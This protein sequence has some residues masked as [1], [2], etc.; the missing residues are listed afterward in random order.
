MKKWVDQ[1]LDKEK[2]GVFNYKHPKSFHNLGNL[3]KLARFY[4][5]RDYLHVFV[6]IDSN[7]DGFLEPNEVL[8]A[9]KHVLPKNDITDMF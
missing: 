5:I 7:N 6:M 3:K 4:H 9:F 1:E 2:R 8:K